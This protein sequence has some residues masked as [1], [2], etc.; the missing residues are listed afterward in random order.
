LTYRD[1][2]I[3]EFIEGAHSDQDLARYG[4]PSS[5]HAAARMVFLRTMAIDTS[6]QAVPDPSRSY[7]LFFS[8]YFD[9]TGVHALH[10]VIGIGIMLVLLALAFKGHFYGQLQSH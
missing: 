3:S 10:M 2:H 8:L 1:I 6:G 4:L 7:Q 9:M 5:G